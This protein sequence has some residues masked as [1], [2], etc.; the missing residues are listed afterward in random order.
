MRT[1]PTP[2]EELEAFC[3]NCK[4][5]SYLFCTGEVG[6]SYIPISLLALYLTISPLSLD[7]EGEVYISVHPPH[8]CNNTIPLGR[9]ISIHCSQCGGGAWTREDYLKLMS[10]E[11]EVQTWL[12]SVTTPNGATR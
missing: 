2:A 1:K 9:T 10:K 11:F 3:P 5:S 6:R 12:A 4:S 7:G 8:I